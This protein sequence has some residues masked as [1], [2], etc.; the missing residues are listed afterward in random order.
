MQ[1]TA[2]WFK[3]HICDELE[4]ATCYLK[5]AVDTMKSYPEWSE[6]F[7]SM[8]EAE[9]HHATELYKMFMDMYTDTEGTDP[10]MVN[11]RDIVMSCFSKEMKL[12]EDYKV[13]YDMMIK[14]EARGVAYERSVANTRINQ[15]V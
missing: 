6:K 12:I 13:T 1:L 14:Q 7:H 3:D 5:L 10:Y 9:E 4:G 2:K 11:M 8:S 15:V